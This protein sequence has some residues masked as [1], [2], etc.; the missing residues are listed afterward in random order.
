[1]PPTTPL[2][3]DQ[4][5]IEPE[6]AQLDQ[7][8]APL[9]TAEPTRARNA[10]LSF[11]PHNTDGTANNQPVLIRTGRYGELSEHELIHL[12]DSIED[13]RARSR[14]RES[15]YIATF[16]WMVLAALIIWGPHYLWHAPVLKS[17][18]DMF[19]ERELTILNAPVIPHPRPVAPPPVD[20]R[21]LEHL[22]S[23]EPAPAP[24]PVAPTPSTPEPSP[25]PIASTPAP[26]V[27]PPTR[28]SVAPAPIID[29]PTPQPSANRGTFSATQPN[30]TGLAPTVHESLPMAIRGRGRGAPLGT[31][32]EILSPNP[33]NVDFD[34]YLRRLIRQ[35]Y[36]QWIPLI[37]EEVQP[38]LSKTGST[39][40]RF[41]IMPDGKI[42]GIWLDG[43]THDDAINRAAWGSIVGVGQ[44]EPLP[45]N[46]HQPNLELRIDFEIKHPGED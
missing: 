16:V 41:R 31:G 27:A 36:D 13:E 8:Q 45:H 17:P 23:M 9:N 6:Q 32:V 24:A 34:P 43:S 22:R 10:P 42:G 33:D 26:T 15:L 4:P 25:A 3:P 18:V 37:P 2:D 14:F 19:K 1:M 5:Q 44:F 21:T 7:A 35:V 12:L 40:I 28:P 11:I 20:R 30:N 39:L 29:A 46:Y 38:P